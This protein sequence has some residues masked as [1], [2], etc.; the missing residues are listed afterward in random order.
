[1]VAY[2]RCCRRIGRGL[3]CNGGRRCGGEGGERHVDPSPELE[4]PEESAATGEAREAQN[5]EPVPEG[6]EAEQAMEEDGGEG[7]GELSAQ[8]LEI[9]KNLGVDVLRWIATPTRPRLRWGPN[10]HLPSARAGLS[11]SRFHPPCISLMLNLV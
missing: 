2:G 6:G 3:R 5:D 10:E 7:Q 4:E 8:L 11:S 1:M 9:L